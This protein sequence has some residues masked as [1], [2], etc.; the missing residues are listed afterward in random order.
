MVEF[1]GQA[2]D[3]L[4][5][6]PMVLGLLLLNVVFVGAV[7][8]GVQKNADRHDAQLTHLIDRCIEQKGK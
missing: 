6:Q 2:I 7:F 4:K 3:A 8:Y 1:I 5:G